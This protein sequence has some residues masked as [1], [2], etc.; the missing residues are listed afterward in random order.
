MKSQF[1]SQAEQQQQ[2]QKVN[3]N[4]G[5]MISRMGKKRESET[6]VRM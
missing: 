6:Q 2:Q 1:L 5:R 4:H 3:T